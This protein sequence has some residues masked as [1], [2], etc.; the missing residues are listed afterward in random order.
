ME[1]NSSSTSDHH[2]FPAAR[3]AALALILAAHGLAGCNTTEGVGKDIKAAGEGIED[4]ARDAK[5]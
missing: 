1:S 5:N 4:T 2:R 3:V